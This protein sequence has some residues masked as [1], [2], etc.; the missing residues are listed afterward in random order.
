[1]ISCKPPYPSEVA[2]KEHYFPVPLIVAYG[3]GVDSTA[4]L[5]EFARMGIR[6]DMILFADT[7][8]EK[9][10]T[11]AY[12]NEIGR[13]CKA[14]GFPLPTTVCYPGPGRGQFANRPYTSL[15]GQCLAQRDLPSLAYGRKGCSLKWKRDPQ[16]DYVAGWR[17]ALETWDAG[18]RCIK[19]IGYDAGPA[20]ARRSKIADDDRY[21]YWYPLR[22]WG[23]DR[24]Q[25]KAEI[26]SSGLRVPVKSACFYCPASKPHEITWLVRNYPDLADRIVAMERNADPAKTRS[27]DGLWRKPTRCRPGSMS[28]W[29]KRVR[30][31]DAAGKGSKYAGF[32]E[33]SDA[34]AFCDL[35]D[36]EAIQDGCVSG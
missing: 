29:I 16:N 23:W 27:I 31:A 9:P 28:E 11:Y 32:L 7:G 21:V 36:D 26:A 12:A 18:G 2:L 30:K 17:P 20:D 10:D 1:V 33:E 35:F 25:C 13:F 3:M 24:E 4:V 34:P 15:E 19:V 8:D 22:E 5:V 14:V 6:P